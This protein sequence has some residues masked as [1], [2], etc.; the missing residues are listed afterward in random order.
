MS[1]QIL[2]LFPV[3]SRADAARTTLNMLYDTN[4]TQ[5]SNCR[6]YPQAITCDAFQRKNENA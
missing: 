3:M 1:R 6:T 2:C 5:K 4:A